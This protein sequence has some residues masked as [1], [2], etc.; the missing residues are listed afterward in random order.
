MPRMTMFS[1]GG[2]R[3][4]AVGATLRKQDERK[5]GNNVRGV[6]RPA[7]PNQ[8]LAQ[9]DGA[10]LSSALLLEERQIEFAPVTA[11]REFFRLVCLDL[12]GDHGMLVWDVADATEEGRAP[13]DIR[14]D[15]YALAKPFEPPPSYVSHGAYEMNDD[16]LHVEIETG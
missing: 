13:T 6:I 12:Q 7:N 15:A 16:G 2:D 3:A 9:S 11:S 10:V 5:R 1:Q 4:T 14:R 8:L